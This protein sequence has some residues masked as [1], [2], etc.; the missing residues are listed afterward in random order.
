MALHNKLKVIKWSLWIS[1]WFLKNN[2]T[3]LVNFI[4]YEKNWIRKLWTW[5]ID[6]FCVCPVQHLIFVIKHDI[7]I[8]LLKLYNLWPKHCIFTFY[9]LLLQGKEVI[10]NAKSFFNAA[11]K[12]FDEKIEII[13]LSKETVEKGQKYC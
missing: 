11:C 12:I 7:L 1:N 8:D 13:F 4:K 3:K 5:Q 9:N 2:E 6:F 10:I